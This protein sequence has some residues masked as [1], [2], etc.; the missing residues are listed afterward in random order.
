MKALLP[1]LAFLLPLLASSQPTLPDS[2]RRIVILRPTG[3]TIDGLPEMAIVPD[4][5]LLYR[6]ARQAVGHTFAREIVELYFLAQV[7]LRNKGER[8]TIEPAYLALTQNQG[9]YARF[10]F[11]LQDV[12][13][14]PQTPYVDIVEKTVEAPLGRLMSFTQLY[15][16]EMGH[17]IYRLLSSDSTREQTSRCVDMHYF[18]VM[19]DYGTAFNEGYAEHIENAARR[20][21]P[22]DSIRAEIMAD[23]RKVQE[24]QPRW[25]RGFEHDFRWPLRLGYYKATM[26]LWYQ[27]LEDLKR[28]EQAIDG[29]VRFKNISLEKGSAE[30]RLT[31]RNSGLYPTSEPRNRPQALA[32]E[33]AVSLFFTRLFDSRLPGIYREPSFYRQFLYDTTRQAGNPEELFSP[34][35]N[36]YLKEFVVLHDFVTFEHSNSA[37]ALDFLEGYCQSFPDEKE[38]IEQIFQ[39]AFGESHRYLP[40]EIWLL[41]KGHEHRLLA[42]DA[43]GAI[44]VPVYTFDI[45]RAELEDLL[46]VPGLSEEEA[47]TILKR[48][49]ENGF[50]N[51]LEEAGAV[52]GL[53]PEGRKALLASAFD[54]EYFESLPEPELDITALITTPVK[55]LLLYALPYLALIWLLAFTLPGK[56]K[57]LSAKAITRRA[58]GYGLLWLLFITAGLGAAVVSSGPLAWFLPFLAVVLIMAALIFRKRPL[59]L[60]RSLVV[61]GVM[62]LLITYNLL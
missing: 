59:R 21:E 28:Y 25:K 49:W 31:F 39:A 5:S 14:M 47:R 19:T 9:G 2:L 13:A 24:K 32:T 41:V 46:T 12:G 17:V 55:R 6:K 44:T 18:S 53:S 10:G 43:F 35:Q 30:D 48:R 38:A 29:M 51:S 58:L 62:G 56:E 1:C 15:P 33:G 4:T 52:E 22:N 20:Y 8:E 45:N 11:H 3:E 42:L 40:P 7:Y 60:K 27:Q 26:V 34:W 50:F 54:E 23:I 36:L 16:H 57:R 61:I 37:Q